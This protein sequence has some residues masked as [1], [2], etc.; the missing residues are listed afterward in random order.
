M[1]KHWDSFLSG[2]SPSYHCTCFSHANCPTG[3]ES[4]RYCISHLMHSPPFP[5][6]CCAAHQHIQLHVCL[7]CAQARFFGTMALVLEVI[8]V[9][10]TMYAGGAWVHSSQRQ[11]LIQKRSTC[12]LRRWRTRHVCLQAGGWV[13]LRNMALHLSHVHS[14]VWL[15]PSTLHT[16]MH[17]QTDGWTL[18]HSSWGHCVDDRQCAIGPVEVHLW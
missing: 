4:H 6:T 3:T 1:T 13:V 8:D 18:L 11:W 16:C 2:C 5:H 12:G 17:T 7:I 15:L 9:H 14:H 10:R